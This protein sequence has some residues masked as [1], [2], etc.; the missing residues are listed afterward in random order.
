VRLPDVA[1]ERARAIHQRM[2][3]RHQSIMKETTEE[4]NDRGGSRPQGARPRS[5]TRP[6][7]SPRSGPHYFNPFRPSYGIKAAV[8]FFVFVAP[9]DH[10]LTHHR[11]HHVK[12]SPA[13]RRTSEQLRRAAK[14]PGDGSGT[15]KK[16][17]PDQ[18]IGDRGASWPRAGDARS[19]E[20][21][22]AR[23]E[24]RRPAPAAAWS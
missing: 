3:V 15:A 24:C 16:K 2:K 6:Q 23:A 14:P 13:Q 4:C 5:P 7:T 18:R 19:E 9:N 21:M 11:F 17:A 8:P 1:H 10:T 22:G 12:K 20:R